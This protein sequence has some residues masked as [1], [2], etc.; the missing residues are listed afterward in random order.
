MLQPVLYCLLN[1]YC[2][3]KKYFMEK[4]KQFY[5]LHFH[6]STGSTK[7]QDNMT[8]QN[9]H[10]KSQIKGFTCKTPAESNLDS[11]EPKTS[12]LEGRY[13]CVLRIIGFTY[14]MSHSLLCNKLPQTLIV[15]CKHLWF[16]SF[17]GPEVWVSWLDLTQGF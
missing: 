4:W 16:H 12:V 10:L 6:R 8:G 3:W 15:A 14:Y 9:V 1:V 7:D 2:F 13:A 11:E 17:C 5:T